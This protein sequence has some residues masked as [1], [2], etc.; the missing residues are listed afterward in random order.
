MYSTFFQVEG[1]VHNLHTSVFL[2]WFLLMFA[3]RASRLWNDLPE[4][5]AGGFSWMYRAEGRE[6]T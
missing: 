4:G 3:V 6:T 2:V 5:G 1:A